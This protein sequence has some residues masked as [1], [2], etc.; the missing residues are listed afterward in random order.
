MD[1][2]KHR[3]FDLDTKL[4]TK[5]SPI[6][7]NKPRDFH[8]NNETLQYATLDPMHCFHFVFCYRLLGFF[9]FSSSGPPPQ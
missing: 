3:T 1:W 6:P 7:M 5:N 9:W 4:S 8:S 2:C